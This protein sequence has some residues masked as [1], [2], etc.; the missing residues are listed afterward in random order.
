MSERTF[1]ISLPAK[2]WDG[3]AA[4]MRSRLVTWDWR[5][6]LP[7]DR[8]RLELDFTNVQ[9]MEPWALAM[10]AA[11]GLSFREQGVDARVILDPA[12]P[13]N[14][15]FQE[16]G[17]DELVAEGRTPDAARRAQGSAQ[18]TGLHLIRGG[19]DV[20][21]FRQSA[22]RLMLTHCAEAADALKFAM[23]E[24]TR[25]VVQHSSSRIGGVAIAQHF[26]DRKALQVAI[27]DL[28][29]GVMHSL[30]ARYP[31]LRTDMEALRLAILPH[32]SGSTVTSPYGDSAQNVGLGLFYSK[33][34]AWRSAGSFWMVSGDA[35]LAIRGDSDRVWDSD[36]ATPERIY[37]RINRWP[38]TVVVLD[39]PVDGIPDFSGILKICG[40]LADEARRLSG[41]AGLD[42]LTGDSDLETAFTLRVADFEE[43]NDV[44]ARMRETEL[45][46]RVQRG[47]RVVID[48]S[49]VRA[50]S[51][52]FVHVLLSAVFQVPGSL[53]RMSFLGCTPSAR[54]VVR[55]VAAYAARY[56][57]IV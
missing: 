38:G 27:C 40:E 46:P 13:S 52:S 15:Y 36:P 32:A 26:P 18:D 53:V 42:F 51:A 37:R 4:D 21:A 17:L 30:S 44:G 55:S 7:G 16:M 10:L 20:T 12:S 43:D 41:P 45:L 34:I 19:S 39:F 47:E 11:Y 49:G 31:E 29:I 23:V 57:Q 2:D 3:R 8:T 5:W 6:R 33:E 56:R 9:F 48:F 25:N 22:S 50:P 35:L 54:E 14:V 1:R 28:G 24:L